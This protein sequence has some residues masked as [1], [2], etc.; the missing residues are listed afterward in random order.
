MANLICKSYGDLR[1]TI[2]KLEAK[3]VMQASFEF[4]QPPD[5]APTPLLEAWNKAN[6]LEGRKNKLSVISIL[7]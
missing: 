6:S 5:P 3:G 4:W 1:F 2:E 7:V